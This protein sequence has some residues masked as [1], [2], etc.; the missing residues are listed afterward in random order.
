MESPEY[1]TIEDYFLDAV[2]YGDNDEV[3]YCL[4]QKLNP[5]VTDSNGNNCIR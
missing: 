4:T 3:N 1:T 5:L 2:K